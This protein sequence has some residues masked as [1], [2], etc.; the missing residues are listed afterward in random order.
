[1]HFT[2]IQFNAIYC[3]L[4]LLVHTKFLHNDFDVSLEA[5]NNDELKTS[6]VFTGTNNEANIPSNLY[7]MTLI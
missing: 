2:I 6:N 5:P 3:N 7:I 1:M 4:Y